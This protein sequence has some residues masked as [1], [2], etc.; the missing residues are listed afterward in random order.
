MKKEPLSSLEE[1]AFWKEL[2]LRKMEWTGRQT[3]IKCRGCISS[4]VGLFDE[5]YASSFFY[6]QVWFSESV[7][8]LVL[9]IACAMDRI[10]RNC[11][12]VSLLAR[13]YRVRMA[14]KRQTRVDLATSRRGGWTV[15]K[16]WPVHVGVVSRC[17]PRRL[18]WRSAGVRSQRHMDWI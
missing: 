2:Y 18:G 7:F 14:R 4:P 6:S 12:R 11:T 15:G 13:S 16:V 10:P 3:V 8:T 9:S 17:R 5:K 1:F